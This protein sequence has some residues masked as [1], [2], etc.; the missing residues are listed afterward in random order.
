MKQEMLYSSLTNQDFKKEIESSF[1]G[2][3]FF[4]FGEI[5]F[6]GKII[7][8][9]VMFKTNQYLNLEWKSFNNY[10]TAKYTP[11]FKDD[12]SK[13]NSY[14]FY[15]CQSDISKSLKYEIENNKFSTRKIVIEIEVPVIDNDIINSIISEHIVNDNIQFD[16]K[17][18]NVGEF[19]KNE[20]LGNIIN[21]SVSTPK[22]GDDIA[23]EELLT[24]I[25]T[26]LENEN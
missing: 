13:W 4:D 7:I 18:Q 23:L 22:K 8:C 10:I 20:L 15:L 24:K 11:N 1:N 26:E 12:Y 5:F 6:G 16:V 19:S 14:L 17:K 2:I 21:R 9:F 25:E 3:S